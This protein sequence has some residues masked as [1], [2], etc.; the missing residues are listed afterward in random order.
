[1]VGCLMAL[2][3]LSIDILLPAL[4]EIGHALGA[5]GNDR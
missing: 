5:P 4:A 3:A 1:M 2:N